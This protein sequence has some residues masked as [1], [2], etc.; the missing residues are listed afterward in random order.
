MPLELETY[1]R[2]D[3]SR[4]HDYLNLFIDYVQEKLPAT[5]SQQ[6]C[7]N[8]MISCS[9]KAYLKVAEDV[10][11]IDCVFI[12]RTSSP[13]SIPKA[14]FNCTFVFQYETVDAHL[15]SPCYMSQLCHEIRPT[16]VFWQ[17]MS[18]TVLE[19]RVLEN[20]ASQ[21]A[22]AA[23]GKRQVNYRNQR[24]LFSSSTVV[25]GVELEIPTTFDKKLDKRS[26]HKTTDG[27]QITG[28]L[29]V[30][31]VPISLASVLDMQRKI[32]KLYQEVGAPSNKA[33]YSKAGRE[34]ASGIH[35]HFSWTN[36]TITCKQL[37]D[38]LYWLTDKRGG[39]YYLRKLG[40]KSGA[41]FNSYSP[42]IPGGTNKYNSFNR[43]SN[44]RLEMRWMN[45]SPDPAIAAARIREAALLFAE[46]YMLLELKLYVESLDKIVKLGYC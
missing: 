22:I 36:S 21:K 15:F 6:Y 18:A 38:M 8:Q 16:N 11:F 23:K 43:V 26:W 4:N 27:S 20:Y 35:V 5:H 33:L 24:R 44:N 37:Q 28:N 42:Y 45:N 41:A 29:E 31:S 40:G 14:T 1:Y 9:D 10:I 12:H 2:T 17:I 39:A 30:V 34:E 32:T 46:A 3:I 13:P 7:F 25:C 19:Q